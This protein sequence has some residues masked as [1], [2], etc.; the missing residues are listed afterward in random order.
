LANLYSKLE[1][2]VS[3]F[4]NRKYWKLYLALI[5]SAYCILSNVAQYKV[6]AHGEARG[7]AVWNRINRQIDHP[8]TADTSNNPESHE[9]RLTFRLTPPL[10]GKMLPTDNMLHRMTGLFVIQNICGLLFFYLLILFAE[11]NFNNRLFSFLL[12]WCFAVLYVGKTFFGD[13]IFF[14]DG[15][16]YLFLLISICSRNPLLVFGSLFLAFYTDERALIGSGF[17][18][19]FHVLQTQRG[20]PGK[21][22]IISIVAAIFIYFATRL[23]MQTQLGMMTPSGDINL[24]NTTT[25]T[26]FGF[27]IL[28][29]F[30]TFKSFWLIFIL[31]LFYIKGFWP[32]SIYT[33][34]LLTVIVG[35]ISVMD[36]SRSIAYGF[37]GL[38]AVLFCLYKEQVR[39]KNLN[40]LMLILFFTSFINPAYDVH[41]HEV[42]LNRSI[43]G[44]YLEPM[45][46]KMP[47]DITSS[48]NDSKRLMTEQ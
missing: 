17:V 48:P 47:G 13:M 3:W 36:F 24:T 27:V 23:F 44:K 30:T 31:G 40:I 12:P 32:R 46:R 2:F 34:T 11:A 6:L 14:F 25:H 9:A 10:I 38:L 42:F 37:V 15:L 41:R 43:L 28:G 19:L 22:A 26:Y 39:A 16:A 4:T 35:G 21:P 29:V 45:Y 8:F 20:K 18:M 5:C 1:G 33:I 7:I